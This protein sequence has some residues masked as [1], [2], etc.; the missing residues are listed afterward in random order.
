MAD[1]TFVIAP[2]GGGKSLFATGEL[3][4]ELRKTER[5][6]VTNLPLVLTAEECD[7]DHECVCDWAHREIE[8]PINVSRRVRRLED[9]EVKRFWRYLPGVDLPPLLTETE[10]K[11]KSGIIQRE[12]AAA[13]A[14]HPGCLYII[15]EVHLNFSAREWQNIGQEVEVYMSQLRKMNDDLILVTQHPEKVDKN[16]RRNATE[17]L[18]FKNLGKAKLWGG[19]SLKGRFKWNKFETQPMRTDKP[20]ETGFMHLTDKGYHK[21][22]R[23]MAGV[24]V[25]GRLKCEEERKPGRGVYVWVIAFMVLIA[26]AMFVPY[27]LGKAS[28]VGVNMLVGGKPGLGVSSMVKR[29]SVT[30][31][32][33]N[34]LSVPTHSAARQVAPVE[35]VDDVWITSVIV[36]PQVVRVG[37]SDGT[38][39]S[40]TT[41]ERVVQVTADYVVTSKRVLD[42]NKPIP[43]PEYGLGPSG[44]NEWRTQ[45]FGD[46]SAQH[47]RTHN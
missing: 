42:R 5:Y 39:L 46:V 11:G 35:V 18:Y 37:L 2:I 45:Q 23:T 43:A 16:F 14:E 4:K 22:Y 12:W 41:R 44:K 34:T 7:K 33:T 29:E 3:C 8:R 6:I 17:W 13:R 28:R 25:T 47:N 9:G 40:P 30:P 20:V 1:I 10:G 19:V 26:V 27:A 32:V 31:T 36:T 24:G 38:I 15:D 21:L